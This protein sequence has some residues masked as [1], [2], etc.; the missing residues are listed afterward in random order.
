MVEDDFTYIELTEEDQQK[1]SLEWYGDA[2]HSDI[3]IKEYGDSPD[4]TLCDAEAIKKGN[5]SND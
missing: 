4:D 5:V 2:L 1:Q 3:D